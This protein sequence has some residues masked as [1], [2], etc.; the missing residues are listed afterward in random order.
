MLLNVDAPLPEET[1]AEINKI[2]GIL[3][4]RNVSL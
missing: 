2:D 3:G 4:V 1:M